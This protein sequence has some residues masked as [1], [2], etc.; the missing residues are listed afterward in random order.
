M[1][2]RVT[3]AGAGVV[4]LT[5]AVRLAEAGLTVDVL[6]RELPLETSSAA[7]AG[8]WL[9]TAPEPA[10][11]RAR[12]ARATLRELRELAARTEETGVAQ[13]PGVL[14]GSDAA[15]ALLPFSEHV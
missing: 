8:L 13:R 12:W 14:L 10:A 5:C 15:A 2:I 9:P 3:V 7:G 6:A 4:G 1:T 11:R